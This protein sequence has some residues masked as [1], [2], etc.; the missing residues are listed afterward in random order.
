MLYTTNMATTTFAPAVKDE[1][2]VRKEFIETWIFDYLNKY[3]IIF[4]FSFLQWD[5]FITIW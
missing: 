5:M 4:P 3:R 1:L 2:K